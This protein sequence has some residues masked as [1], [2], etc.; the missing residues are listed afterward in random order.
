[1]DDRVG[2]AAGIEVGEEVGRGQ[3]RR[4]GAAV[5]FGVEQLRVDVGPDIVREPDHRA[6][7][8]GQVEGRVEVDHR[9]RGAGIDR[10]VRQWLDH[11]HREQAAGLERLDVP[12]ATLTAAGAAHESGS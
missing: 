12:E 9:R 7:D 2:V 3:G 6:G 8:A 1:M 5:A 11:V 4:A 10:E